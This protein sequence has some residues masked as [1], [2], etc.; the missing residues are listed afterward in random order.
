MSEGLLIAKCDLKSLAELRYDFIRFDEPE[1]TLE[2]AKNEIYPV[3][4][5]TA[6]EDDIFRIGDC[7]MVVVGI[8]GRSAKE[9]F[10]ECEVASFNEMCSEENI[11]AEDLVIIR[12][13]GDY[14]C[15]I[16]E[17]TQQKKPFCYVCLNP[18]SM[19][20]IKNVIERL[21]KSN[22]LDMVDQCLKS[23]S[24]YEFDKERENLVSHWNSNYHERVYNVCEKCLNQALKKIKNLNLL[25]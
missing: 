16:E 15:P 25:N 11:P 13:F 22:Y 5:A 10:Y 7:F 1:Y 4:F 20:E 17:K 2:Q 6:K 19:D 23:M 9:K 8:I 3:I 24:E 21:E 12:D 18:T 14:I